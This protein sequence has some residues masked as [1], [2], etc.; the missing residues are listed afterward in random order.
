MRERPGEINLFVMVALF[1]L[2]FGITL[3]SFFFL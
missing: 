1:F 2:V 3:T